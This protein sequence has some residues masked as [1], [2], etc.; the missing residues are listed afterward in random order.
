MVDPPSIWQN[1]VWVRN[2]SAMTR[3]QL[4]FFLFPWVQRQRKFYASYKL[5]QKGHKREP[6]QQQVIIA[7][8]TSTPENQSFTDKFENPEP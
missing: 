7:K 1:Y 4:F 5:V 2:Y 6:L 8:E 3:S